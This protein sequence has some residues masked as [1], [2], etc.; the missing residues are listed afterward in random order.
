ML[1]Y[2]VLVLFGCLLG[3]TGARI[4]TLRAIRLRGEVISRAEA[5]DREEELLQTI[6]GLR[7]ELDDTQLQLEQEQSSARSS[8]A[9]LKQG[10]ELQLSDVLADAA[11][12]KQQTLLNCNRL[13]NAIQSMLSLIKTF[14]RWHADM[15]GLLDHNRTMRD[16]NDEFATIVQQVVILALNASIE[17]ARA[18]EQ[19][20]GFAVV[21]SEVRALANRAG[22]LSTDYR[23]NLYKN[24]LIT[25]TT[26]QDLQAGGKMIIGAVI[27]LQVINAKTRDSLAPQPG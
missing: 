15:S 16:R 27:E 20:R 1:T 6:A 7:R 8:L 21:A 26:F 9:D 25:T 10:L 22:I 23:N 24:D 13:A 14:E 4:H 5:Q 2:F 3:V 17:A 19:G 11:S 12:S 18:G